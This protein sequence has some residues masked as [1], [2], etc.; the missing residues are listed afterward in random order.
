VTERLFNTDRRPLVGGE[1]G[2]ARDEAPLIDYVAIRADARCFDMAAM[3][4]E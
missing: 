1:R 4:A 3:L 2:P